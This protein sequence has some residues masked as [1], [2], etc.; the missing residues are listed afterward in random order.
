[1]TRF[2]RLARIVATGLVL[3]GAASALSACNTIAGAGEDT[4]AAG[5]AV[6]HTADD[7][8]QKL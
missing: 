1:M 4:S 2:H 7:V 6:T 5:H 8:K 3:I